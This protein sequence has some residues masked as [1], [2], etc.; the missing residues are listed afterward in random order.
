MRS[1]ALIGG[2]VLA[3]LLAGCGNL[4]ASGSSASDGELTSRAVAAVMLD[5]LPDGTTRREATYVDE[6]SPAGMVG[7]DFRYG[8]DGESDG[9]LV[10]VTVDR[11][12]MTP[13]QD[14]K[15][16]NDAP[17]AELD[18][19]V[20]LS[21]DLEEPEEDPGIV[22][23]RR[24]NDAGE[25]VAVLLAGPIIT[26]DPRK[27]ELS[28]SVDE[29]ADL[30]RDPRLRLTPTAETLAAGEKV[31]KWKDGERDRSL[32]ER[33]PNT[34]ATIAVGWADVY[35]FPDEWDYM[36]PTPADVKVALGDGTI[37][38]RVAVTK[39]YEPVGP[40]TVDVLAAPQV[41]DWLEDGCLPGFRCHRIEDFRLVW[42]PASGADPGE[43]YVVHVNEDGSVSAM[44][45]V[46]P[47]LSE[48][49]RKAGEW[50][51]IWMFGPDLAGDNDPGVKIGMTTTRE[52]FDAVVSAN[53]G[54]S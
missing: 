5:H 15:T 27:Q 18:G 29:L 39:A 28:P 23:L 16:S 20:L 53:H 43:A 6:T 3:V 17:C 13:C 44:H 24:Q 26:E 21:W 38:G 10:R 37:G 33:V 54:R 46:G 51:G 9:D 41:S 7:A 14:G 42:R 19:G 48:K 2:V 30:V 40:G 32:F 35:G 49:P 11:Q 52:R 25:L 47:R 45:V 50:A 1:R 34:D 4:G 22:L 8:G 12:T 36:G 31:A